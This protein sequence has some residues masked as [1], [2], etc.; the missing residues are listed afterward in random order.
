MKGFVKRTDFDWSDTKATGF[1]NDANATSGDAFAEA[2]ND[3]AGDQNVLHLSVVL[4]VC[5]VFVKMPQ[6]KKMS[7]FR[8]EKA[9]SMEMKWNN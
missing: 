4:C 6:R 7:G 9:S 1:E 5:K 3:T 2:T 8:E